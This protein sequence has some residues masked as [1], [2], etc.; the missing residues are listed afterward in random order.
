MNPSPDHLP[1]RRGSFRAWGYL[2]GPALAVGAI[3]LRVALNPLLAHGTPYLLAFPVL[4]AIA[5]LLGTGPAVVSSVAAVLAAATFLMGHDG[6]PPVNWETLYELA[7]LVAGAVFL[8]EIGRRLR[9]ARDEARNQTAAAS[10]SR[11]ALEGSERKFRT[12]YETMALGVVYQDADGRVTAANPA[13]E[14]ILGLTLAQMQGREAA[15][16][17]WGAIHEDGTD[18]PEDQNPAIVALRTGRPVHGAVMGINNPAQGRRWI[19]I[20]AIPQTRPGESRPSEVFTTFKDVTEQREAERS[21]RA[22]EETVRRS[23]ARLRGIL[24][25]TQ[26]SIWLFSRDAVVLLANAVALRRFGRTAEDVVGRRME[27]IL[28]PELAALRLAKLQQVVESNQ[29]VEFEDERAGMNFRHNF[30]PVP[31]AAG[32]VVA[33]ASFSRDITASRRNEA[34]LRE[35]SLMLASANDAIIGYDTDYRVTFWNRSA[36]EMYGYSETEAMGRVS[37]ELFGPVYVGI[38]REEVLARLAADGRVETESVRTTGDGRKIAVEAHVIALRN[39]AGRVTGYVSVDRDITGRKRA[40]AELREART[41]A[42]LRAAEFRAVLDV[43]PA[44]VWVAHDPECRRI[45]G[46]AYADELVMQAPRGANISVSA[47]SGDAAVT[48]KVFRAGVELKP[49]ELPAQVAAATAR[50]VPA[51]VLDLV[52]QD[53]RVARLVMGATPFLDAQGRVRGAVV[54]GVDITPLQR[55]EAALRRSRAQQELLA[56]TASRLLASSTPQ[57]DVEELCRKAMEFLDCQL[58]VNF[59]VDEPA[60]RLRLNACAGVPPKK[61]KLIEGLDFGQAVCGAVAE[62]GQPISVERIQTVPDP[63]ATLV[64]SMGADAYCCH[65]LLSRGRVIGTLSFGTTTR[66]AFTADEQATMRAVADL[67]ST[68]MQRVADEE[69]LKQARDRLELRVAERTKE[70]ESKNRDLADQANII[71]TFFRYSIEPLAILDREFNFVRV[72]EAYARAGARTVDEYPGRNHFDLYPS[73]YRPI[74]EQ[75]RDTAKP[76]QAI[77]K[78]FVYADHPEWGTTYW[79]WNIVPLLDEKGETEFLVFTLVDVS[80][81]ERAIQQVRDQAA[82]IDLTYDAVIVRDLADRVVLW[83]RGAESTYGYS[84][85]EARGK[86][87]AELLKTRYP[88]PVVDI[89]ADLE[90]DWQWTGELRH[91]RKDGEEIIVTSRWALKRDSEG[92]PDGVLEINRD[93]TRRRQAERRAEMMN[94]LLRPFVQRTTRREY[95]DEVVRLVR[96]WTGC[97]SVGLRV[98]AGDGTIPY[99]AYAGFSREFLKSESALSVERD[100]GACI[101]ALTGRAEPP[102]S[103]AFTPGGSYVLNNAAAFFAGVAGDAAGCDRGACARAGFESVAVIPIRYQDQILGALHIADGE[104]DKLPPATVELLESAVPLIGEALHRF[105]IEEELRR[106]RDHLA[107][108][109]EQATAALTETNLDLQSEIAVR[110][111]AEA[112]LRETTEYL[113]NL[114]GYAN[115]PII[116]W[117]REFKITRF[118]HAFEQLTG[119]PEAEVKGQPLTILFPPEWQENS[120][121]LI[122]RT[123]AGERWETVEIPIQRADGRVRDV[124]WNSATLYAADGGVLATIAQGQDITE[125]KEAEDQLRA[126]LDDLQRSNEELEQFAYVASHDLQEPL[127][128]VAS[129]VE[130]LAKRYQGQIDDK[131][132]RYI[133]YALG[134][135]R[136]MQTLINDLLAFS[137]VGRREEPFTAVDLNRVLTQ[138]R[139]NLRLAIERSGAR[140]TSDRLPTVTGDEVQLA[141]LLQNLLDNA[142]K[143]RGGEAPLVQVSARPDDGSWVISVHDNGIGIAPPHQDRIFKLFQRLHTQEEYP[144]T[145][146]GLSLCKKIVERHGGRIQVE[147]EPGKG[148]TFSFTLPE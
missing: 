146:I 18:Y 132:D 121:A 58:F 135:A 144:G 79:D 80:E 14:R 29:P 115:A 128:M 73:D 50:P 137:R 89:L 147:S 96:Q 129:Y 94:E 45:T 98:L 28:T 97:R 47:R 143:F 74:F 140:I 93:I 75:V 2:I 90:R 77:G 85:G 114:V 13:A 31:D 53:G 122:R 22:I 102:D 91:T 76:Y 32:R 4:A 120:M 127:R 43:A 126:T 21:L 99:E 61:V 56:T 1:S 86:A 57:A 68:A 134:G 101:R 84:V 64:K 71:D 112:S 65:P 8:G 136:R 124:V 82:L 70:L 52:F 38:T 104:T 87:V 138:A 34:R 48:Y 33:V 108:E 36:E 17:R 107:G 148:T 123:A 116:I 62:S 59:L 49:E 106:H 60:H 44:A 30:Y 11:Q 51:E 69:E 40:E 118:N 25:A 119:R 88:R 81:R 111:A 67:V 7:I 24:D 63:R 27:D 110:R 92:R 23:E 55:A 66:P 19:I 16:P 113:D 26:E 72:N 103:T 3:L 145:G 5:V 83:S 9:R 39:E 6:E 142:I 130:L 78:P 42:E 10:A 105:G 131:A 139:L 37:V 41:E 35:Q 100:R 125:R 54:A 20:D 117:D 133:G 141:Q 15:D 109:I 95:L 12:M 46:N